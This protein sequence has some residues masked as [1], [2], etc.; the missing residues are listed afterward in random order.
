[1]TVPIN[2][3]LHLAGKFGSRLLK[4]VIMIPT[5]N[6]VRPVN[7]SLMKSVMGMTPALTDVSHLGKMRDI[8]YLS[9][10]C[11]QNIAIFLHN[12]MIVDAIALLPMTRFLT[13]LRPEKVALMTRMDTLQMSFFLVLS[14]FQEYRV[15]ADQSQRPLGIGNANDR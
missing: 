2:D 10:L 7:L 5:T 9:V 1:L 3:R 12:G 15:L 4:S 6:G 11:V 8:Y 14:I 13:G